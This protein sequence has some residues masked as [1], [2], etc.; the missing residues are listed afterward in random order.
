LHTR[1]LESALCCREIHE[2][3]NLLTVVAVPSIRL[4]INLFSFVL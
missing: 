4:D 1:T 2:S 3:Q